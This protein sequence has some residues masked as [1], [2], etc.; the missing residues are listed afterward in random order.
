MARKTNS[1]VWVLAGSFAALLFLG[2]A[3]SANLAKTGF[4][5]VEATSPAGI[6]VIDTKVYRDKGT[7]IV[8]GRLLRTYTS[9]SYPG[10]VDIAIIAPDGG[11]IDKTSV[12]NKLPFIGRSKRKNSSFKA[13]FAA[14]P[15]E[16]YTIHVSFHRKGSSATG[17]FDCGSNV[18]K[19]GS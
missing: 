15:P 5:N 11:I 18:A 3:G 19:P 14:I 1:A 13:K 10:H 4:Y 17:Q 2:C 16:G 8:T 6:R 9:K 7:L 12:K